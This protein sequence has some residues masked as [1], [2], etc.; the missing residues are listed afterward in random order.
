MINVGCIWLGFLLILWWFVFWE[1]LGILFIGLLIGLLVWV[2]NVFCSIVNVFCLVGMIFVGMDF[3][4]IS[5]DLMK[6]FLV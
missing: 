3:L 1:D 4:K 2:W 6:N 5:V